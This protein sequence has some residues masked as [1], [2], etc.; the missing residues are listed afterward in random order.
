MDKTDVN[1]EIGLLELEFSHYYK[2]RIPFLVC[3]V[4]FHIF[5]IIWFI[6]RTRTKKKLDLKYRE[7]LK[8]INE[9]GATISL[10]EFLEMKQRVYQA[11]RWF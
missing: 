4:F 6:R 5:S 10:D 11:R 9:I 8:H 2:W 3:L 1:I 7:V